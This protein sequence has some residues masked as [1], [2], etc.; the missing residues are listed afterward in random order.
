MSQPTNL[1]LSLWVAALVLGGLWCGPARADMIYD[2]VGDF[3]LT[4]NPNGVWSYGV[5]SSLTGGTFLAD[6]TT[7]TNSNYT[8]QM[9]W[10][11][12]LGQPNASAVD[13]NTSGS[14]AS[15]L[16]IVQPTN[17]LR[18]DGEDLTSDVRF[19]APGAGIYDVS[20]LFQRIDNGNVPVS[21]R[22]NLNGVALFSA[23]NFST[24]NDQRVFNLSGLSLAAGDVLDFVEGAP[25]FNNDSTGLSATITFHPSAVPEPSSLALT[26]IALAIGLGVARVRR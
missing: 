26:T 15:Y 20:G 19:T 22:V 13:K 9:A 11:N 6:T 16:S 2:A 8:G 25:Q 1:R 24:F 14:T 12:G 21:V 5:L 10:Y 17:L 4:A 23:D 7:L 3:S 18:L